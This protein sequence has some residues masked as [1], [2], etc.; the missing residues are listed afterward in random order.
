VIAYIGTAVSLLVFL[1]PLVREWQRNIDLDRRTEAAN[2]TA[3]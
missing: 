2:T 1:P 3:L